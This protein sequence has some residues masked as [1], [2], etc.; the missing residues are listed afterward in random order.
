MEPAAEPSTLA[1]EAACEAALPEQ[2][3]A[4]PQYPAYPGWRGERALVF[5]RPFREAGGTRRTCARFLQPRVGAHSGV[6]GGR[7]VWHPTPRRRRTG[8]RGEEPQREIG[9]HTT[10]TG[11]TIDAAS[12]SSPASQTRTESNRALTPPMS[13][14]PARWC[15]VCRCLDRAAAACP[16]VRG[17][18]T[19]AGVSVPQAA[20]RAVGRQAACG[21]LGARRLL[22][23]PLPQGCPPQRLWA[24]RGAVLL[25]PPLAGA[26]RRTRRRLSAAV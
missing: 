1:D 9:T 4:L 20:Q 22:P 21:G 2:V 25:R 3:R 23:G 6:A 19:P 15:L 18:A 7:A 10:R 24:T 11:S 16:A 14:G 5:K 13:A 8:P 17:G 12:P 26:D